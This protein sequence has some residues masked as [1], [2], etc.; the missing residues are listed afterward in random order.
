VDPASVSPVGLWGRVTTH[1]RVAPNIL[2]EV[3]VAIRG[4]VELF[5]A[6][7]VDDGEIPA[8]TEVVVVDY[9]PPRTVVVARPGD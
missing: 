9:T 7:G 3:A 5:Y 1:G 4:G 8:G 2:G 6:V